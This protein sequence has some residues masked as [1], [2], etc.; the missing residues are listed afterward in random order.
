[1]VDAA[2]EPIGPPAAEEATPRTA[3]PGR[4]GS[5]LLRVACAIALVL[6]TGPLPLVL[7]LAALLCVVAISLNPRVG[8]YLLLFCAAL[9]SSNGALPGLIR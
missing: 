5:S 6:L 9:S 2:Q 1:M 8:L 4:R 7:G 3:R